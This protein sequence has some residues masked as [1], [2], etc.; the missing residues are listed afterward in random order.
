MPFWPF[1][2]GATLALL[3]WGLRVGGWQVPA[4]IFATYC[5]VRAIVMVMPV[6]LHEIGI[7]AAWLGAATIML[8]LKAWLPGFFYILS[9]LTY[10]AF[11]TF[12]VRIEY[13]GMSPIVAEV[14]ALCALV[15][16]GGGLYGL[17]AS[18]NSPT[19]D[20]GGVLSRVSAYSLGVAPR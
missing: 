12:G 2:M 4:V 3:V 11:L 16:V 20:G 7:C 15:S 18:Y 9:G 17:S 5:V 10:P 1:I 13:M 8:S 6:T 19:S 14:F